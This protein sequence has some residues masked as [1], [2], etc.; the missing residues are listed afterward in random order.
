MSFELPA[1]LTITWF[2]HATFLVQTPGSKRILIDPWLTENPSTPPD[3]KDPG[4][5]D[6][7]LIT[8]GHSDHIG[9]AAAV[10]G[11]T[12]C[13]VAA[14]PEIL[15]YL[16]SK[17]ADPKTFSPM[18]KGGTVRFETLG[19]SVTMTMAFHTG[20]INNGD[21]VLYG[22]EPGGF[23]V[24]LDSG[25][26]FYFAGDTCAF[27]DMALIAEL[28]RPS[29]AFLPIG[30]RF[31]MGPREAAKAAA[32]LST[33]RAVVPMHF[34]TFPLLTGTPEAFQS[35]IVAAGG[36]TEVLSLTPGQTVGG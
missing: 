34:G 11:K 25:F 10:A 12:G 24:T 29:L 36:V 4:A 33:V 26:A 3:K 27:S 17:G 35:E 13:T 8:H 32:L 31:T 7:M 23:V 22:G 16:G 20:G 9:D 30:D 5:V 15:G 19:L 14:V 18:N 21:T 28:Y 6:L 1:G 2:G